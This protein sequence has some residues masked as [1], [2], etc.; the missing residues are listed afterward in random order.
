VGYVTPGYKQNWAMYPEFFLKSFNIRFS[1]CYS[2]N[3]LLIY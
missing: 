2:P 1:V 3:S